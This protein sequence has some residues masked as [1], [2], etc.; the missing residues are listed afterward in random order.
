MRRAASLHQFKMHTELAFLFCLQESG[1]ITES[2][3]KGRIIKITINGCEQIY[4]VDEVS[5]M[6]ELLYADLYAVGGSAMSAAMH[7]ASLA[8]SLVFN[9]LVL[10]LFEDACSPLCS[11]TC[12]FWA[13]M[14]CVCHNSICTGWS[15]HDLSVYIFCAQ[16]RAP[17][18][19]TPKL[20]AYLLWVH[21]AI[22]KQAWVLS[23]GNV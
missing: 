20:L 10:C 18:P 11:M 16:P 12:T 22:R 1:L 21:A 19:W 15:S 23:A 7:A 5:Q 17:L 3:D 4:A 14:Y 2:S 9:S 6:P 13:P 8:D